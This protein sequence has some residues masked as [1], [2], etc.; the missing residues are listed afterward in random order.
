MLITKALRESTG[1]GELSQTLLWIMSL[2]VVEVIE[3]SD[4]DGGLEEEEECDGEDDDLCRGGIDVTVGAR[5]YVQGV[6]V[7]VQ[8]TK[9]P[10]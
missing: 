3:D 10:V 2:I 5:G 8:R 7:M 4:D 9:R 6:H 1:G